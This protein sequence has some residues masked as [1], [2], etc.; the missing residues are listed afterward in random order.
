[1]FS[2]P[3]TLAQ[4]HAL[5]LDTIRDDRALVRGITQ[6]GP[7]YATTGRPLTYCME[8]N[9]AKSAG[10]RSSLRWRRPLNASCESEAV[11]ARGT[12]TPR[13][14][15][16]TRCSPRGGAGVDA[17]APRVLVWES[18]GVVSR[19]SHTV[20]VRVGF[21]IPSDRAGEV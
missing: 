5:V 16:E 11:L 18:R 4:Y 9:A 12:R 6:Y 13:L 10:L 17:G 20:R 7:E 3:A 19:W 8:G 14:R 15:V 1:M 21:S 2:L